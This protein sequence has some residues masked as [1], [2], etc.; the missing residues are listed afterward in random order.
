VGINSFLNST[1]YN[2][3][4][5]QGFSREELTSAW[6]RNNYTPEYQEFYGSEEYSRLRE[7]FSDDELESSWERSKNTPTTITQPNEADE[8]YRQTPQYAQD[9]LGT[10]GDEWALRQRDIRQ[11]QGFGASSSQPVVSGG[12]L[13]I[14]AKGE[15]VT[16]ERAE[17]HGYET[18]YDIT[19]GYGKFDPEGAK[20]LTQMTVAEVFEHMGL[21]KQHP[22]NL[23]P[24]G[25]GNNHPSS[26]VGRYQIIEPTLRGLVQE[27][28]VS[29]DEIFSQEL[30]DRMG[31][32][33]LNRRG[34]QDYL[35][36]RITAEEFQA[37]MSKEWASVPDPT[38]GQSYYGQHTGMTNE[39]FMEMLNTPAQST[40]IPMRRP[41]EI[42]EGFNAFKQTD[43]YVS[44]RNQGMNE[45][46]IRLQYE[47]ENA[48]SQ[49]DERSGWDMITNASRGILREVV[50]SVLSAREV[51]EDALEAYLG[52][53][54][55]REAI[56][57]A[58]TPDQAEGMPQRTIQ[59]VLDRLEID[60]TVETPD[61]F[62]QAYRNHVEDVVS[63]LEE[64]EKVPQQIA[65]GITEAI[66]PIQDR[67]TE[68]ENRANRMAT[69]AG[70]AD[71]QVSRMSLLDD[72]QRDMGMLLMLE[73][74]EGVQRINEAF[75]VLMERSEQ[76][77][78]TEGFL[79][80]T[81]SGILGMIPFAGKRMIAGQLTGGAGALTMSALQGTGDVVNLM[82]EEGLDIED[83][84]SVAVSAGLIYGLVE[85]AQIDRLGD[86]LAG[87]KQLPFSD[88]A[89][90]VL[91]QYLKNVVTETGAQT[92]EEG[93]QRVATET[94]LAVER[95]RQTGQEVDIQQIAEASVEE[96][97]Q[98]LP[99]MAGV[100]ILTG[101]AGGTLNFINTRSRRRVV[102]RTAEN[103][104]VR[105][106]RV[107]DA[108]DHLEQVAASLTPEQKVQE[109]SY[110]NE[111]SQEELDIINAVA[112][113]A[114]EK[115]LDIETL[116]EVDEQG[117]TAEER[118]TM[119]QETG[120]EVVD[121]EEVVE[122]ETQEEYLG[123]QVELIE[124]HR[125][126]MEAETGNAVTVNE[127]A[128]DWTNKSDEQKASLAEFYE[129]TH[130]VG[131]QQVE[132]GQE[133]T[134]TEATEAVE[135]EE[136][137]ADEDAQTLRQE[138]ERKQEEE[139]VSPTTPLKEEEIN[140][141]EETPSPSGDNVVVDEAI[142]DQVTVETKDGV[143]TIT[144]V[145]EVETQETGVEAQEEVEAT[146]E[147]QKAKQEQEEAPIELTEPYKRGIKR[148]FDNT[149]GI[150]L[151]GE[152]K[153]NT[154]TVLVARQEKDANGKNVIKSYPVEL[155]VA[156]MLVNGKP[157]K[158]KIQSLAEA[159]I[160]D[161]KETAP[162]VEEKSFEQRQAD[163][164]QKREKITLGR[165]EKEQELEARA[166]TFSGT[167]VARVAEE[168]AV[169]KAELADTTSV[170][171]LV[172][173]EGK[174]PLGKNSKK[175]QALENMSN[176][177]FREKL[178][179][180]T[181]RYGK[182]ADEI[183]DNLVSQ[184][185]SVAS[186]YGITS[187][188]T[189][190]TTALK[191]VLGID[192]RKT[193]RSDEKTDKLRQ[194]QTEGFVE[195]DSRD[196][197]H[198][199]WVSSKVVDYDA[200]L[201]IPLAEI[202]AED[203][204]QDELEA[205]T[206]IA[207]G[208]DIIASEENEGIPF[209]VIRSLS[210]K[211][212]ISVKLSEGTTKSKGGKETRF[213][214]TLQG[215]EQG[216]G[217]VG[218]STSLDKLE[219]GGSFIDAGTFTGEVAESGG[220][221]IME[222]QDTDLGA[223]EFGTDQ[224]GDSSWGLF[225]RQGTGAVTERMLDRESGRIMELPRSTFNKI[226]S[227]FLK[228]TDLDAREM[229]EA[230][231]DTWEDINNDTVQVSSTLFDILHFY[232][233]TG[234][235]SLGT[236]KLL[237][238]ARL[239]TVVGKLVSKHS[240]AEGDAREMIEL[241]TR[242]DQDENTQLAGEIM[243]GI[244]NTTGIDQFDL[245]IESLEELNGYFSGV[246][247]LIVTSNTLDGAMALAHETGHW[248]YKNLLTP[249]QR[250]QYVK[251][252][253][254][255]Y[256]K[257]GQI[258]IE[259]VKRDVPSIDIAGAN[260]VEN[261]NEVFAEQ[262]AQ[263]T[264]DN[265]DIMATMS[266]KTQSVFDTLINVFKSIWDVIR[267]RKNVNPLF[268]KYIQLALDNNKTA[269]EERLMREIEVAEGLGNVIESP[270]ISAQKKSKLAED[271]APFTG[272]T[273]QR[274]A[275]RKRNKVHRAIADSIIQDSIK[276]IDEHY[277]VERDEIKNS[278]FLADNTS[279]L[280]LLR[281]WFIDYA[282]SVIPKGPIRKNFLKTVM[283]IKSTKVSDPS[284]KHAVL[285]ANRYAE[286][287][288]KDEMVLE[289]KKLL[290]PS[291]YKKL[292]PDQIGQIEDIIRE[293]DL[294]KLTATK[295]EKIGE[296]AKTL[297][298]ID[299]RIAS[300]DEILAH[301]DNVARLEKQ[302]LRSLP[303]VRMSELLQEVNEV[304]AESKAISKARKEGRANSIQA[305]A[306]AI[307]DSIADRRDELTKKEYAA[308][309][310]LVRGLM[311]ETLKGLKRGLSVFAN[312]ETIANI[313]DGENGGALHT[314]AIQPIVDGFSE[315]NDY[316]HRAE[317][318]MVDKINEINVDVSNW[319]ESQHS[320]IANKGYA[321]E[322][323]RGTF[324][325][326]GKRFNM[327]KAEQVSFVRSVGDAD[328]LGHII[329]DGMIIGDDRK[330]VKFT[331]ESIS[332]VLNQISDDVYQI[333]DA[334]GEYYEMEGNYLDNFLRESAGTSIEVS[335]D[336]HPILV[337]QD[338]GKLD[339]ADFN[340][341]DEIKSRIYKRSFQKG[342]TKARIKGAKGAI[343]L[344]DIFVTQARTAREAGTFVGLS[345]TIPYVTSVL[346][347][348]KD[349]ME[350]KGLQSEWRVVKNV[351][352]Q[353]GTPNPAVIKSPNVARAYSGLR[354]LFVSGALGFKAVTSA[355][356]TISA[357]NYVTM[358]DGMANRPAILARTPIVVA[359]NFN[360]YI[361][362]I[363][364]DSAINEEMFN[365]IPAVRE[366]FESA[367]ID[368]DF[369]ETGNEANARRVLNEVVT[370]TN[371]RKAL[372]RLSVDTPMTPITFMDKV[373]IKSIFD[374]VKAEADM[375]NIAEDKKDAWVK[376]KVE[377]TIRQTQPTF[378]EFDKA[379]I[380]RA[381]ILKEFT[382]FSSQ[383]SKY[384]NMT[385]RA[386]AKINEGNVAEGI[387]DLV[388]VGVAVPAMITAL[389]LAWSAARGTGDEEDRDLDAFFKTVITSN[390]SNFAVLG[391]LLTNITEGRQF[392]PG[393]AFVG[394]GT[395]I[396]DFA[397]ALKS[398]DE[399]RI[400][401]R[402]KRLAISFG[403]PSGLFEFGDIIK[404]IGEE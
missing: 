325:S 42:A 208:E 255:T 382:M 8:Q 313:I 121:G 108:I 46:Q 161:V 67:I 404:N 253:V 270:F 396:T 43:E 197:D 272:F 153:G 228:T 7:H 202:R 230:V 88:G 356:Q 77:G 39:E 238:Y 248:A 75:N 81:G 22:D 367:N 233:T 389:K 291:R 18:P 122:L 68:Y 216:S 9:R 239:D 11:E 187:I 166:K 66:Y 180:S 210:D 250:Y 154:A 158:A 200:D 391:E 117:L 206:A 371:R 287:K 219:A 162:V 137:V 289:F 65:Q 143:T 324:T 99:T 25:K 301:K 21:M 295:R 139:K 306:D 189:A 83:G 184:L 97:R 128:I 178:R 207:T 284:L 107:E 358:V 327:T 305:G 114:D 159:T 373:A 123:H 113:E 118:G 252:F 171:K 236:D 234:D 350:K 227:D 275:D 35:D 34:Y 369:G 262:F 188:K 31:T 94:G 125:E 32:A 69:E 170:R 28:G 41:Q 383:R 36:G 57:Q 48:P 401:K 400:A 172:D 203:F 174:K 286:A 296:F 258:D 267:G 145:A 271:E 335:T 381:P 60:E 131:T 332:E 333:A 148:V 220:F 279:N 100:A 185:K 247:N 317:D 169:A 27:L 246:E 40:D 205:I 315:Q 351:V 37:G 212:A 58:T 322:V 243:R 303:E 30:Q 365:L 339:T 209:R 341:V 127:A 179:G 386:I 52:I 89:K 23:F 56:R 274:K 87:V 244:M 51:G 393:G 218:K 73:D 308:Q 76:E 190:N 217:V 337:K 254:K 363:K 215:T 195:Y 235:M 237:E 12:V 397:N 181:L 346:D 198:D 366:R 130:L 249:E 20:P 149:T 329:N 348:A 229:S 109:E 281:H 193:E 63:G 312:V 340:S 328:A 318:F 6:A 314:Q 19:L 241:L 224:A 282:V 64:D 390:I 394:Q 347:K 231:A 146:N 251:D 72:M 96:M 326:E 183:S 111:F 214:E 38:T 288:R 379:E 321:K 280:D 377:R 316:A 1:K 106:D 352:D 79:K 192:K 177:Q 29:E 300:T 309:K 10:G 86:A 330:T 260:V 93:A 152:I 302:P 232:L 186:E 201:E 223:E 194:I 261:M 372:D 292:E 17:S 84:R 354:K 211:G 141:E 361:R 59:S 349:S 2:D 150:A 311:K 199:R 13:D 102:D 151:K 182:A 47:Q 364:D 132:T 345:K 164:E 359:K 376:E 395:A 110:S 213:N 129:L 387:S 173:T 360:D 402:A 136:T 362:N 165:E 116:P 5:G 92:I 45:Q 16:Q 263:Y 101:G 70:W 26:A 388:W 293:Y 298:N 225:N 403:L 85:K 71:R 119:E 342:S 277:V 399:E 157:S 90:A 140:K 357:G 176:E 55:T 285:V 105:E 120:V 44:L 283:S 344:E 49:E 80:A 375:M 24:D 278:K 334:F 378:S 319:S 355:L 112:E 103:L 14:I 307:T 384:V 155:N 50:G 242:E 3:L 168:E 104:D 240:M 273:D 304:Y 134:S 62:E 276:Q 221:D 269:K 353:V 204:S 222:T 98:A 380:L 91:I 175:R 268:D 265:K 191:E 297:N 82:A 78:D 331:V 290:A 133:G 74:Y 15:G 144:P 374:L 320:G 256:G 294:T 33:L 368:R 323:E 398:G 135:T 338:A 336:H 54:D 167:E 264:L 115:E 259:A 163:L 299:P 370:K 4:L 266:P 126:K 160:A 124:K 245:S 196:K 156:D 226:W 257:D 392:R 53:P 147:T 61:E 142:Q 95:Q 138:E 310:G 385:Y 343:L